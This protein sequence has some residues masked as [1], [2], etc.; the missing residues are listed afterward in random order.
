MFNTII[1]PISL[2]K[3]FTFPIIILI[4][5]FLITIG[6]IKYFTRKTKN[7]LKKDLHLFFFDH[8]K[9]SV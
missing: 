1:H 3:R 2:V 4:Y 7:I 9:K 8:Q 6:R 5:T